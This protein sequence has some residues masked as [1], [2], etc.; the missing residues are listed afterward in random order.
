MTTPAKDTVY[1]D[2]DDEITA[3]I[4]KVRQSQSQVVAL[5]LPKRAAALQSIV[6]MKL[7]KSIAKEEGKNVVLITTEATLLPMAGVVGLYVAKTLQSKPYVPET[8][9]EIEP[10]EE[11]EIADEPE[12]EKQDTIDIDNGEEDKELPAGA[13]KKSKKAKK[14]PKVPNFEKFRLKLVLGAVAFIA[15]VGLWY[16]AVFVSPSAKVVIIADSQNINTGADFTAST[17]TTSLSVASRIVPAKEAQIERDE[18]TKASA[19]G[20]KDIGAKAS[21]TVTMSVEQCDSIATPSSIP[22]GTTV[23]ASGLSYTTTDSVSFTFDSIS[24]GCI[25]F[26]GGSTGI[27]AQKPGTNYNVSS[28]KFAVS[29]RSEVEAEGSANGGS[30]KIVKVV[31]QDDIDTAKAKMEISDDAIKSELKTQLEAEGYFAVID[32]FYKTD[33]KTESSPKLNEE[34]SEVSVTYSAS[35][36]ML[37]VKRDDV[38]ELLKDAIKDQINV[39]RQKIQEDGLDQ[40]TFKVSDRRTDGTAKIS[41]ST[42]VEVGPNIDI[43]QLKNDIAGKKRGE[44]ENII[45][46]MDGVKDV[47]VDY[48]PFWVNKTTKKLEKISIEFTEAQ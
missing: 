46:S 1:I 43:E 28:T 5:V 29:G 6:N 12:E 47:T 16:L 10:S 25:Y 8:D 32:S 41:I 21:G 42:T 11:I 37:G 2:V 19:T 15:L 31:S 27:T 45:R 24:G 4:D 22:A 17:T 33:E 3:I 34:A 39:E 26:D 38:K 7:L 14:G 23:T 40:A 48:S 30:T 9:N 18:T 35:F 36:K 13:T 20:Q 44:S